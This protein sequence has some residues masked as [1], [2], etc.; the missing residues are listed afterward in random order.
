MTFFSSN[1]V[2]QS[3]FSHESPRISEF[4]HMNNASNRGLSCSPIESDCSSQKMAHWTPVLEEKPTRLSQLQL[5]KVPDKRKDSNSFFFSTVPNQ[6]KKMPEEIGMLVKMLGLPF[7]GDQASQREP[8]N[9]QG[10][11]LQSDKQSCSTQF[12]SQGS[13]E[14]SNNASFEESLPRQHQSSNFDEEMA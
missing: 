10:S 14:D 6:E 2:S 13:Q 9:S 7:Q 12:S 4:F 3:P 11:P 8:I 5:S 1:Q